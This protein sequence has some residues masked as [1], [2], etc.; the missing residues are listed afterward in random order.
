M[1]SPTNCV[2][3]AA[4]ALLHHCGSGFSR[5]AFLRRSHE[6]IGREYP[7]TKSRSYGAGFDDGSRVSASLLEPASAAPKKGLPLVAMLFPADRTKASGVNMESPTNCVRTA[8]QALLHHCGSGFSRDAVLRRSHES[9]GREYPPTKKRDESCGLRWL[10]RRH[11]FV[12]AAMPLLNDA[13]H[14][15]TRLRNPSR[16]SCSSPQAVSES[17][18]RRR[19]RQTSP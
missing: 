1:E 19:Q 17:P 6:S 2:R 11:R 9:I 8:A 13:I 12:V 5:D 16:P 4:Q 3:T 18:L 7:P 10:F 15:T 14:Q